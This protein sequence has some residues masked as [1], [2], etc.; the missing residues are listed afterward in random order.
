MFGKINWNEMT[1]EMYLENIIYVKNEKKKTKTRLPYPVQTTQETLHT[2][3]PS[4]ALYDIMRVLSATRRRGDDGPQ[5][6][7]R[8]TFIT[9]NPAP[10]R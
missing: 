1:R 5:S 10:A 3:E 8:I 4:W 9:N 2:V 6:R 7:A